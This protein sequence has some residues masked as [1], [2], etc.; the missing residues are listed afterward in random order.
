MRAVDW[1]RTA[2]AAKAD[3]LW[4]RRAPEAEGTPELNKRN[5]FGKNVI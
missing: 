4:G 2:S 1:V 3:L 5:R